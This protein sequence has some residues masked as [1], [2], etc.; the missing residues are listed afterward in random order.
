MIDESPTLQYDTIIA[1]PGKDY[2][3]DF[4]DKTTGL[5]HIN[6][7]SLAEVQ[8]RYPDAQIMNFDD[9]LNQKIA[10]QNNELTFEEITEEQFDNA[11]NAL[12][13]EKMLKGNFLIGEPYDHCAETGQP[14]FHGYF[15]KNYRYEISSRPM[16]I[17]EFVLIVN[18]AEE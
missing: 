6:R 17:K 14:R 7:Q 11:L 5:T 16:T 18:G 2:G 10:R 15:Y 9:Y 12:P 13:P 4:V 1:Q 3:I 8:E